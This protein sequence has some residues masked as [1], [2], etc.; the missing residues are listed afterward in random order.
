MSHFPIVLV[1]DDEPNNIEALAAA[2]EEHY[3]VQFAM[4]GQEALERMGQKPLPEIVLLDVV[5]PDLDGYEI[6]QRLLANPATRGS[7]VIFVTSLSSPTD[8]ARGLEL[9]AVDFITKPI[10]PAIVRARVRNHLGAAHA[11]R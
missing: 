5:L 10:S 2:L 6:C 8:E 4:S 9:G 3:E 1:V 7:P 11:D